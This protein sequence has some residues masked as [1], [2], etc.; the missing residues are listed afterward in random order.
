MSNPEDNTKATQSEALESLEEAVLKATEQLRELRSRLE[1]AEAE[2]REA[3]ELLRQFTEG[4]EDPTRLRSRL[5]E[6]ESENQELLLRL[7][8]GK[9]GVDRLL[10]RIRF[11]EEQA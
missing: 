8:K 3:K 11:L 9:E 2:G 1:G 7:G 6:L 5:N 10:A 4:E